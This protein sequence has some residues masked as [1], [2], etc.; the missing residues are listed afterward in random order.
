MQFVLLASLVTTA[1]NRTFHRSN[2]EEPPV[3]EAAP[4]VGH[5]V[6]PHSSAKIDWHDEQFIRLESER[7]GSYTRY[8]ATRFLCPSSPRDFLISLGPN[9]NLPFHFIFFE[10]DF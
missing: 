6:E 8:C 7:Q 3:I 10:I 4:T 1:I 9:I 5:K 2:C